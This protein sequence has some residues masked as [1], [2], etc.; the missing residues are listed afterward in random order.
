MMANRF[1]GGTL[2]AVVWASIPLATMAQT[3]DVEQRRALAAELYELQGG[4]ATSRAMAEQLTSTMG[5][6][7]TKS[8]PADIGMN[9]GLFM[10]AYGEELQANL[11]ALDQL[12]VN[13]TA[14]I[15]TL[16]EL[17]DVI[18]FYKT[19]TG[20]SLL[21]KLPEMQRQQVEPMAA[22]LPRLIGGSLRRYCDKTGCTA[23]QKEKLESMFRAPSLRN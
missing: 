22:L 16:Q 17:R 14:A 20:K 5:Q 21:V 1:W 8:I 19:T 12:S 7:L 10:E 15:L 2:A 4:E 6:S 11:P 23:A 13:S 3:P 9:M 18:A